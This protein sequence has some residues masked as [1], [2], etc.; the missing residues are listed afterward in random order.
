MGGAGR[1]TLP[2]IGTISF[3]LSLSYFYFRFF[4]LLPLASTLSLL[5]HA[6]VNGA[7]LTQGATRG[8]LLFKPLDLFFPPCTYTFLI[9]F[10]RWWIIVHF[11]TFARLPSRYC[12]SSF[13]FLLLPFLIPFL[14]SIDQ[15]VAIFEES[16]VSKGDCERESSPLFFLFI[17][18]LQ[19]VWLLKQFYCT[20]C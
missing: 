5:V 17:I 13:F 10:K 3:F 12:Y 19:V 9:N 14:L 1:L 15:N 11:S 8:R 6:S 20:K 2:T 18:I 7:R 16:R 4:S